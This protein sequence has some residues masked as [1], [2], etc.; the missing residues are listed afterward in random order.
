MK[1]LTTT[2]A[3]VLHSVAGLLLLSIPSQAHAESE[4][5]YDPELTA[6]DL[7]NLKPI[8]VL[9]EDNAKGACWTNLKEVREYAEEKLRIK[10]IAVAD[11][12]T[13]GPASDGYYHLILDVHA[14]R[15]YKD[16]TGPCVGSYNLRMMGVGYVGGLYSTVSLGG[17]S[18]RSAVQID[19]FN[20]TTIE[21][22]SK[23]FDKF[24]E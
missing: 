4:Y 2:L 5:F 9:L 12:M 21:M 13:G 15:L 11:K 24:P 20:R 1:K 10:G 8:H 22:V 6:D 23:F 3:F 17:A 14:R 19:N 18:N 7:R 16:G